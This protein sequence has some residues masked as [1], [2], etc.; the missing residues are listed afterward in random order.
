MHVYACTIHDGRKEK[1]TERLQEPGRTSGPPSGSSGLSRIIRVPLRI[2]RINVSE[3]TRRPHVKP[4]HPGPLPD[5]PDDGRIIRT[6]S[7]I[8]RTTAGPSG[9]PSGSSGPC[10]RATFRAEAHVPIRPLTYPFAH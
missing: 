3:G 1:K 10:L 9:P 7:R 4:D 5:H 2:I 8:V 6:P